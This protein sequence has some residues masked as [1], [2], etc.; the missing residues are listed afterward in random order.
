[1]VIPGVRGSVRSRGPGR[2]SLF[3]ARSQH[4]D[5]WERAAIQVDRACRHIGIASKFALPEWIAYDGPWH[6]AFWAVI[7]PRD[8]AAHHGSNAE[9]SQKKPPAHT[10]AFGVT[11]L[12]ATRE[13]KAGRAPGA[14]PQFLT[15]GGTLR[16][17]DVV[18]GR[19][20]RTFHRQT[21][22]LIPLTVDTTPGDQRQEN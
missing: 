21:P 3:F 1:V 13:V 18:T 17:H 19:K 6:S 5:D 4:S 12:A 10:E 2:R 15:Q 22:P 14:S 7:G 20:G 16:K 9:R 11:R 8:G